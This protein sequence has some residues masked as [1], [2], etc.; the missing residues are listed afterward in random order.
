MAVVS[1]CVI[2]LSLIMT[3]HLQTVLGMTAAQAGLTLAPL[4][5]S[6]M[7]GFPV[8][9]RL[10]ERYGSGPVLLGGLLGYATALAA[11]ALLAQPGVAGYAL[12]AP[13]VLAG[14]SQSAA[15]G[16][17][18]E[19][20]TRNISPDL[21]GAA[22]GVFNTIR[23]TGTLL[24]ISVLGSLLQAS[25]DAAVTDAA[26]RA[27]FGSAVR[28]ILLVCAASVLLAALGSYLNTRSRRL[29]REPAPRSD[30]TR[31]PSA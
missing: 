4:P 5:L 18:T 2:T 19:L 1:M 3:L 15:F 22:S 28:F 12:V 30:A 31:S 29:S 9:A 27:A 21:A 7:L 17:I 23:Q 11:I 20:A 26:Y 14:L 24:G 8:T 10:T 6:M 25:V 13:L 16:P